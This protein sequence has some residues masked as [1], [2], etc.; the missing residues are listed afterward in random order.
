MK[1]QD[2]I[3]IDELKTVIF[4]DPNTGLFK[5]LISPRFNVPAD[6]I[7]GRGYSPGGYLFI[8]YKKSRYRAH[9]LAWFYVYGVW[10]CGYIDHIN[11]DKSDNRIANLRDCSRSVN[12][13]NQRKP[14][15]RNTTGLLGVT[16]N[17]SKSRPFRAQINCSGRIQYIGIFD[18]P[19]KAHAA[20][21]ERKRK[22]HEGCTI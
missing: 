22:L 13:Q 2:R 1:N 21:L 9:V 10:P 14:H 19:E 5:W 7:V 11:G 16:A 17:G 12:A 18:T 8:G 6:S 20:Y 15:S 4:Y 3:S